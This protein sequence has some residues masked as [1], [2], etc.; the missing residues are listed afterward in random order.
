MRPLNV[1]FA[2]P[3][4][5]RRMPRVR[6][7][8]RVRT[9][10]GVLRRCA[11]AALGL[12]GAA[13]AFV[14][15][16]CSDGSADGAPSADGSLETA[17]VAWTLAWDDTGLTQTDD[18]V[19]L[20][21]DRGD[22]ITLTRAWLVSHWVSLGDCPTAARWSLAR[23]ARAHEGGNASTLHLGVVEDLLVRA[24]VAAT[25]GFAEGKYCFLHWLVARAENGA[26]AHATPE[27]I[28]TSLVLEGQRTRGTS[29]TRPVSITT[30]WSHGALHPA[31]DVLPVGC[32]GRVEVVVRRRLARVLDG[33]D[34]DTASDEEIAEAA[35][36]NL[37]DGA[38]FEA[39]CVEA[40]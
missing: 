32:R 11:R 21:T 20:T 30:W 23:T 17:S 25:A 8:P 33:V 14:S 15:P 38:R 13:A 18:G 5:E 28:G 7:A 31:H 3:R 1:D 29:P 35:L 22:E 39:R 16:A 40:R 10:L 19:K 2:P 6:R 12:V 26:A 34:L 9:A 4:P 37:V 24:P 36:V 27:A